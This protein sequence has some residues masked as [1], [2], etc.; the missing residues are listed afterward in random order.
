M[1]GQTSTTGL[2]VARPTISVD[3]TDHAALEQGLMSLL[4]VE[5]TS[6]LYRCEATFGNWGLRNGTIDFLYFDRQTLDFGK[7]LKIK[8]G[9]NA[10][11]DGRV[12]ALEGHFGEARP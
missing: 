11:F 1:T 3:G 8:L 10:L 7:S 2:R 4:I 9:T 5:Q 12:T 6:G